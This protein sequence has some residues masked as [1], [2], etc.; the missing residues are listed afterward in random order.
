MIQNRSDIYET[1]PWGISDQNHFL[2]MVIKIK[3]TLSPEEVLFE[4]LEIE[5]QLG[6]V[7]KSKW[8]PR[9]IDIDILFYDNLILQT[10][11]LTIPHPEIHNRK[12][13]L[14]PLR[15]IERNFFHPVLNQNIN[16]ILVNCTDNLSVKKLK[17][18]IKK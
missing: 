5:K 12:F 11:E 13:I 1:A 15:Q 6:R 16:S 2:N 17:E 7:R 3:T 14:I 9:L 18:I 8:G 10:T 4:I